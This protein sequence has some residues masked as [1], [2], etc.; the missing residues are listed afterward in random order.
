MF[1]ADNNS[2]TSAKSTTNFDDT[3][4]N[5]KFL[6]AVIKN[7]VCV[8]RKFLQESSV[9]DPAIYDNF[10]L[11]NAARLGHSR[12]VKLL[13][14]SNRVNPAA[15]DNAAICIAA[16]HDHC[17]IVELLLEDKRID[18]AA[19]NSAALRY[20]AEHGSADIV[21]YLILDGRVDLTV[22][23]NY[24]LKAAIHYGHYY[25]VALLLDQ[26]DVN[27]QITQDYSEG[28]MPSVLNL[29]H[30]YKSIF[31][32]YGCDGSNLQPWTFR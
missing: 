24:P 14:D 4:A 18:P 11:Q 28:V 1:T 6:E 29:M 3:K 19:R 7:N 25:V 12:I 9:V 16:Y 8:V 22:G 20:A 5:H 32:P 27:A 17:E 26:D 23:Y 2:T 30:D 21:R 15:Q 10:A 31:M 13:L